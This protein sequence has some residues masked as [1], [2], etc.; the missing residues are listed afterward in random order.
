MTYYEVNFDGIVGNTHHYGGLAYGNTASIQNK[1]KPANPKAAALQGLEKMATLMRLG[2]KQAVFPPPFR[3]DLRFLHNLGFRGKTEDI[4]NNLQMHQPELLHAAFS[5]SSMWMANG[6]TVAPSCDTEDG[7]LHIS[8]A[9]LVSH[10]HRAIEAPFTTQVFRQIFA[11]PEC[12][13][14]HNPLIAQSSFADEG[15]AN[16]LRLVNASLYSDGDKMAHVFVYGRSAF[17][18]LKSSHRYPARQT[19]EASLSIARRHRLP[20]QQVIFAQQNPI[21]IDTGV[22]HNDVISTAH[23]QVF[24]CHEKAFI[25]TAQ[26]IRQLQDALESNLCLIQV[27]DSELS[28]AQAIQSYLFNSQII[29]LPDNTMVMIAPIESQESGY[30][31]NVIDRILDFDNPIQKVIYVDCRQSMFNG[32]GPACLRLRILMNEKELAQ[33]HPGVFL[34]EEKLQALLSWVNRYYRD[35]V[36]LDDL[37]DPKLLTETQSALDALTQ[38]LELGS[39]YDFQKEKN[40]KTSARNSKSSSQKNLIQ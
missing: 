17:G 21:A 38:I 35:K 34:T 4:L 25:N 5:A 22:F 16:H 14:V 1:G 13:C 11:D 20:N 28:L 27:A 2:V 7:R 23:N 39:I 19:L 15:A 18:D 3:P 30:A 33:C 10:L 9:N 24:L 36:S 37:I 26:V 32:G 8:P 6:A 12:F 40:L 31:Q 29:S